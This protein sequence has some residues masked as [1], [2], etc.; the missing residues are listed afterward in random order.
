MYS[1]LIIILCSLYNLPLK[2]LFSFSILSIIGDA[3][4]LVD[5]VNIIISYNSLI[6]FKKILNPGLKYNI[7]SF[8]FSFEY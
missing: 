2:N 6:S 5:E 4:S 8:L 3:Y 1:L 7:P